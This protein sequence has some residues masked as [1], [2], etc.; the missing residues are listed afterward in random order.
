VIGSIYP[1]IINGFSGWVK[2]DAG[3]FA[4]IRTVKAS[5]NINVHLHPGAEKL[6][7]AV[8][9]GRFSH[10]DAYR[11]QLQAGLVIKGYSVRQMA[12]R[13]LS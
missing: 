7:T 5:L 13:I 12:Q 8:S 10:P 9:D 6:L 3:L 11:L 1:P 4:I 2:R